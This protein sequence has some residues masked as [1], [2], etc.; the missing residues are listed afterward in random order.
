MEVSAKTGRLFVALAGSDQVAIV[1][2][3]TNNVVARTSLGG[4]GLP[5]DL[6]IDSVADRVYVTYLLNNTFNPPKADGPSPPMD[7]GLPE[8]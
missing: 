4:L 6:V 7:E 1:N 8:P 2:S 5:Q 3:A